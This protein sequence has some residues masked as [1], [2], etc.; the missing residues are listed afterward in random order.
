MKE[1][2]LVITLSSLFYNQLL[3]R[4]FNIAEARN[5][6]GQVEIRIIIPQKESEVLDGRRLS[7]EY[8]EHIGSQPLLRPYFQAQ[9][10]AVEIE[11]MPK[12]YEFPDGAFF[13]A[14]A[15][16]VS[17]GT[18]AIRRLDHITCEMKRLY[19]RQDFHGLG[20]GRLLCEK[21][22]EEAKRLGYRRM[23]LDNSRSVMSKA[24]LLYK[25]LGFYEIAP[26]NE[27]FVEDAYFMEKLL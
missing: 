6:Y 2:V 22:I 26:Y 18:I 8:I 10:F 13:V 7:Y 24:N 23:R 11:K 4:Y 16:G 3:N 20:I 25:E 17:A 21:A 15:D 14:Y 19:V 1:I 9:N 27:N 5:R 12:G